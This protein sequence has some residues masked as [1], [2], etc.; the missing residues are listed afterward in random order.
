MKLIFL[1]KTQIKDFSQVKIENP[2]F[3][4]GRILTESKSGVEGNN[5]CLY[6]SCYI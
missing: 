3:A 1:E 4:G 2:T 5:K 6:C